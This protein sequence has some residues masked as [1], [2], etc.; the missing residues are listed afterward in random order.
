[1]FKGMPLSTGTHT[2]VHICRLSHIDQSLKITAIRMS[3]N[4]LNSVGFRFPFCFTT[5]LL[6]FF[7]GYARNISSYFTIRKA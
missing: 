7:L 6:L 4:I 2:N 5:V 1:M 3:A